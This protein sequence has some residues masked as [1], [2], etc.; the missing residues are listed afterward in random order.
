MRLLSFLFTQ[1]HR[2]DED[3]D[4]KLH[5]LIYDIGRYFA[6]VK[7]VVNGRLTFGDGTNIDNIAGKWIDITSHATGGTETAI[8]HD[9]GVVPVGFLMMIPPASGTVVRGATAWSTTHI[10]LTFSANSQT[11]RLFIVVPPLGS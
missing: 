11:S 4:E 8:Q 10:Y 3:L 6:T 9:L 2:P 1:Q 5:D 7:D